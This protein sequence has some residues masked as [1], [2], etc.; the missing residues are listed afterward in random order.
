[1]MKLS[2]FSGIFI[3]LCLTLSGMT[4]D[5]SGYHQKSVKRFESAR[6]MYINKNYR[7]ALD[8]VNGL[9]EKDARFVEAWLLKSD[10]LHEMDSLDQ[11]ESCLSGVLKIDSVSY[12]KVYFTLGNIQK[13]RGRYGEAKQSYLHFIDHAGNIP[14]MN[15]R[16]R[17]NIVAC[18]FALHQIENPVPFHPVNLGDSVNTKYDEYWPSISLDGKTLIFT[19]LA[20]FADSLSSR[21]FL[22]EDFFMS[23][24]K[25]GKWTKARAIQSINTFN[26]EGAQALSPDGNL[27][28]FT[29]CS[30]R[31]SWGGC[32]IYFSKKSGTGWTVP[33]NAGPPVNSSG[34]ESQPS[35]SANNEF[36]YFVSNRKGGKGGMD[37]WRCRL[38][39]TEGGILKWGKAE[40][41]GDS[42]NTPGNE[43]SPF[44]HPDG[45]TLFFS[46][47]YWPGMGGND[48]F[49]AKMKTDSSWSRP[50][51]MG[52]PI[53][54]C[55]DERGLVVDATGKTA[56][57][58]TDKAGSGMDIFSFEMPENI[59][60]LPV[61]YV[62]GQVVDA[63]NG[64]PL[65]ADIEMADPEKPEKVIRMK[66]DENG[67]FLVGLPLGQNYLMNASAPG[68]LFYSEH[69][70]LDNVKAVYDPFLMEIRLNPVE[71][72][73]VAVLR[74]IFFDTGA[75]Q[76]LPESITEL[77]KLL[78]FLKMNPSLK[79]EIGGHTDNI[80]GVQ[81]NL[82]L[83]TKRAE[84]VYLFLLQNG[85]DKNRLSY[86]GY[87][88]S[89][90]VQ[91][92]ETEEGRA[93]N[94][95]TEFK[96]VE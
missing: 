85:V 86:R 73:S 93:A 57:Y 18:D 24:L 49:Y 41:L 52:Y 82:D 15:E 50:V 10:I 32:D 60:P 26:N 95:R 25:D 16:A 70:V 20:P 11:E 4:Q 36:L 46:S 66:T 91:T 90:P 39:G 87:G 9:I 7:L 72:G 13:Q 75:Y 19:R 96:I 65:L 33:R 61:T 28:F 76:L 67:N 31:D 51:N 35:V 92:N 56:Y 1:M 68:Y 83:S 27:L 80:G 89:D 53:N 45:Q 29:A 55:H 43:M 14:S 30:R 88:F 3:F 84:S 77:N 22:Q 59:R 79:I 74:N 54:T 64:N 44:I 21:G 23:E 62:Q 34:W 17:K 40:N 58:S 5:L 94:R 47:D 12:P 8:I 69:F 63:K 6:K 42:I 81:Y 2:Q 71:P 38:V 78:A 48:I 37:I